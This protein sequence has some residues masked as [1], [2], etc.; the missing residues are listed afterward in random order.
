MGGVSTTTVEF[1][2]RDPRNPSFSAEFDVFEQEA[3]QPSE[4]FGVF[5]GGV[6]LV[7]ELNKS[8]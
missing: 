2:Q 5:W 8:V 4:L 3:D 6:E 7:L 1:R